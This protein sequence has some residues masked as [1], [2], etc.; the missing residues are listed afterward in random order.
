MQAK[1]RLE[2]VRIVRQ[3]GALLLVLPESTVRSL[4][5]R[6]GQ[7]VQIG[8]TGAGRF[9]VDCSIDPS[10]QLEQ[11]RQYRGCLPSKSSGGDLAKGHAS[12]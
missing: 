5:L 9:E 4:A 3:G 6:E 12:S 7:E 10:L 2:K 1:S 11:L 8:L